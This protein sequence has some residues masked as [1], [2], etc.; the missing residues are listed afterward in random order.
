MPDKDERPLEADAY[1]REATTDLKD[2]TPDRPKG[3]PL[4]T[5]ILIGLG[6]GVAAGLVVN[7]GWGDSNPGCNLCRPRQLQ[8]FVRPS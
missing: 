8:R 2:T 3:M 6:V 7:Y 5:R 1:E 4:H